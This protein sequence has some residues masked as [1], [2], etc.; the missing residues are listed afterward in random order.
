[1]GDTTDKITIINWAQ[2]IVLRLSSI[3]LTPLEVQKKRYYPSKKI[4]FVETKLDENSEKNQLQKATLNFQI[5][6]KRRDTL[7]DKVKTLLSLGTFS[8][9]FSLALFNLLNIPK[10]L[11]PLIIILAISITICI[12]LCL[13]FLSINSYEAP[14]F[15]SNCDPHHEFERYDINKESN[16]SKHIEDLVHCCDYNHRGNDFLADVYKAAQRYFFVALVCIVFLMIIQPL[17][18]K[19]NGSKNNTYI[20]NTCNTSNKVVDEIYVEFNFDKYEI[21]EAASKNLISKL[22]KYKHGF[23]FS[24]VG[25]ADKT[26][27][28]PYN[29][30]LSLMR[31]SSVAKWLVDSFN[32][33]PKRVTLMAYGITKKF[34]GEPQIERNRRAVIH[35]LEEK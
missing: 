26:G 13:S 25:Y 4:D 1:M 5:E 35:V 17:K 22:Q 18:D 32:V 21:T 9:T 20:F 14:S 3:E 12:L 7:T 8:L 33:P 11:S 2:W 29:D 15:D 30:K 16:L 31:A 27:S 10:S 34:G 24:I 19:E 28:N 6:Q 23:D